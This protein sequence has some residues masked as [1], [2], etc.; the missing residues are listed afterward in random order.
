M[1]PDC[2]ALLALAASA[3]P[4]LAQEVRPGFAATYVCDGGAVL[5]VAYINPAT[6]P[7]LAVASWAGTLI[8]M[9]AGPTGSGVR[10]HAFDPEQGYVW[11]TKGDEGALL[12]ASG[13]GAP[14]DIVLGNCVR[15][16]A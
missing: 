3:A 8:P 12:R 6:G 7:S 9:Q 5:Q 11:H 15:A 10:Y 4:A 2:A 13:I 14:E 16:G 1:R